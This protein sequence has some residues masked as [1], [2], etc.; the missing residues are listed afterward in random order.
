MASSR[1]LTR[2]FNG[3]SLIANEFAKRS[4]PAAT[5]NFETLIKKTLLSATDLTGLTKGKLRQ[6]SNPPPSANP[7][8]DHADAASSSV[9]YFTDGN[10]SQSDSTSTTTTATI[11]NDDGV[12]CSPSDA[13]HPQASGADV[14]AAEE[15]KSEVVTSV[16]T[17]NQG[18]SREVAPSPPLR[19]RRPRERKVPAT[20]FSRA[21]GL[22]LF[23]FF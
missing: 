1:D 4:L 18:A 23:D 6:F 5:D 9:V 11:T 15:E 12:T 13:C 19:K 20:P 17:V 8:R 2:L 16:E 21:L 3:L 10:P 22:V 7:T 14:C